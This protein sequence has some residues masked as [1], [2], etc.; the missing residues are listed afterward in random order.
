M[1]Q[2]QHLS[3]NY[4]R[5]KHYLGSVDGKLKFE[6]HKQSP[7]YVQSLVSKPSPIKIDLI[8]P[9]TIDPNLFKYSSLNENGEGRSSSLVR[10]LALRALHGPEQIDWPQFA[11]WVSKKYAKS[12]T[13]TILCYA[14]RFHYLLN[15]NLRDIDTIPS[16]TRNNTIKSLIILSK[17]LGIH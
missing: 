1:G 11:F 12:Y 14:R 17:F 2:L 16:T 13:Q 7:Q 6:Y 3:E 10:T 8:D 5:V 4:Y 9:K 15:G